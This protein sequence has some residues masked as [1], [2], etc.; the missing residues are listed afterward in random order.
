MLG[1]AQEVIALWA[2]FLGAEKA[3]DG[4]EMPVQPSTE[5]C[6]STIP[7]SSCLKVAYSVAASKTVSHKLQCD[8]EY[9]KNSADNSQS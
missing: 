6:D 5:H 2:I 3:A 9:T 4:R 1:L 8:V 7:E